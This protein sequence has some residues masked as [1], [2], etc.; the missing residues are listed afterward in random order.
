MDAR[1]RRAEIRKRTAVLQRTTLHAV[2][3][4]LDA[5]EGPAAVALVAILTRESWSA[6]GFDVPD[7]ARDRIPVRFVRGRLT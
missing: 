4:D 3:Q 6:A 1:T 2:E 7:Y 5:I